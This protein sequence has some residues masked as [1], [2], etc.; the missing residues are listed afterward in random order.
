MGD[1]SDFER[2][3]IVGVCVFCDEKCYIIGCIKSNSFYG[4]VGIHEYW[5]GNNSKEEQ[6]AKINIDRK[7]SSYTEKDC[8]KKNH[9]TTAEQVTEK[10]NIHLEDRFH[11]NS[12]M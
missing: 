10:L 3:K 11:K 8:L 9:T 4:Y 5:E 12:P 7:R 2:G 1:L 6:W